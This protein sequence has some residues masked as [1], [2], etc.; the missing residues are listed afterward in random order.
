MKP[1]SVNRINPND[2]GEIGEKLRNFLLN[3]NNF[4]VQVVN[5][6]N[7]NLTLEE[8][9]TCEI[10]Q[11][12]LALNPF[13]VQK[14]KLTKLKTVPSVILL[15]NIKKVSPAATTTGAGAVTLEWDSNGD[16]VFLNAVN[17][18]FSAGALY[19]LTLVIFQENRM[20]MPTVADNP[21]FQPGSGF[22]S[23]QKVIEANKD[24]SKQVGEEFNK[25]LEQKTQSVLGEQ[26][27]AKR[28][29]E[30]EKADIQRT[31]QEAADYASGKFK[32][33]DP[34][35]QAR[36]KENIARVAKEGYKFDA[37][38]YQKPL[39]NVAKAQADLKAA[40][41]VAGRLGQQSGALPTQADLFN[42]VAYLQGGAGSN[43]EP[44]LAKLQSTSG[45][46]Q[47]QIG[48]VG[49]E[50]AGAQKAVVDPLTE[51][52]NKQKDSVTKATIEL[53][54]SKAQAA[55]NKAI[56][57]ADLSK[58]G[59]L[60]PYKDAYVNLS[61]FVSGPDISKLSDK[62]L[63]A[64]GAPGS[65]RYQGLQETYKLLGLTPEVLSKPVMP[66]VQ[67]DV[68]G[69]QKALMDFKKKKAEYDSYGNLPTS[70][71]LNLSI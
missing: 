3:L 58:F 18:T 53:G 5:G 59:D 29:L 63:L 4:T 50:A 62:D 44:L 10:K 51:L 47:S 35:Q 21:I 15:G 32:S 66:E 36:A 11:V 20:P 24:R 34:T 33:Y 17:G 60:Q 25:S 22:F 8:N 1:P 28:Q 12:T 30:A 41:S 38:R 57:E 69:A 31:K 48:E 64:L 19:Q 27:N 39:E 23:W 67:Y 52:I 16:S 68:A 40:Q 70:F 26:E 42:Q 43:V 56:R 13:T 65:K 37:S 14:F 46:L 61:N 45:L 71:N 55:R 9:I 2:L 6:L 7:N 49:Q 54:R